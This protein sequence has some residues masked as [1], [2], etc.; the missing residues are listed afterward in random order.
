MIAAKESVIGMVTMELMTPYTAAMAMSC[1]FSL[2]VDDVDAARS[3][4]MGAAGTAGGAIPPERLRKE[5]APMALAPTGRV[6]SSPS[7]DDHE[8]CAVGLALK[9][10]SSSS[11]ANKGCVTVSNTSPTLTATAV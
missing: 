4:L 6:L 1:A 5:A 3:R 2:A 11:S 9:D 7:M 8:P 10:G